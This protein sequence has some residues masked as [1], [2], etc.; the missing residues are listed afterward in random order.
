MSQYAFCCNKEEGVTQIGTSF[1]V[2]DGQ[3]NVV[4]IRYH[5]LQTCA[6][7]FWLRC[8]SLTSKERQIFSPHTIN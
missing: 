7:L 1:P 4:N 3:V 6:P 2:D 8:G 5:S